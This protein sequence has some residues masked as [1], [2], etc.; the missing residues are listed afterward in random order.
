MGVVAQVIG[1]GR[2]GFGSLECVGIVK[3][4]ELVRR[5]EDDILA[6]VQKR[7]ACTTTGRN[8]YLCPLGLPL[9]P[10]HCDGPSDDREHHLRWFRQCLGVSTSLPLARIGGVDAIDIYLVAPHWP[11]GVGLR[12]RTT[13]CFEPA[14]RSVAYGRRPGAERHNG[15]LE[16]RSVLHAS[17]RPG[18]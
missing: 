9:V 12:T 4:Q 11:I 10:D 16:T 18:E 5:L 13:C 7:I 1:N 17:D 2:Y 15:D 3:I 8:T 6:L 14:R